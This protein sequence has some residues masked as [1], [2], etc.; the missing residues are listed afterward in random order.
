MASQPQKDSCTR[1]SLLASR[2]SRKTVP[3]IACFLWVFFLDLVWLATGL[4]QHKGNSIRQCFPNSHKE[5]G[6]TVSLWVGGGRAAAESPHLCCCHQ[7]GKGFLSLAG[8]RPGSLE[9]PGSLCPPCSPPGSSRPLEEKRGKKHFLFSSQKPEV[10]F[11]P[12]FPAV[13]KCRDRCRRVRRLCG[14]SREP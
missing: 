7:A 10:V 9:G 11:H 5:V 14:P 4:H 8:G 2:G 12:F 6:T 3:L 1:L 13:W